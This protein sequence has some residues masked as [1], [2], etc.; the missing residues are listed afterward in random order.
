MST[1]AQQLKREQARA[2]REKLERLLL[3]HLRAHQLP[4]P[5]REYSFHSQRKWRF[6]FAY[7]ALRIGIECEGGI[8]SGGRH[9]RGTGYERDLDKYN[10]AVLCGWNV[11]RFSAGMIGSGKAVETIKA[12]LALKRDRAGQHQ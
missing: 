10:A 12:L 5:E 6:D 2:Q 1:A 3:Q 4:E 8:H 11:V 9:V 7:P